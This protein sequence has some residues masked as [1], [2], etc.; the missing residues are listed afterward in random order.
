M[1][2]LQRILKMYGEI[3]VQGVIWV[4]DYKQDKARLKSE[5]TKEEWIESEKSKY[6]NLINKI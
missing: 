6:Q 5:M 4:W 2:G 3:N 1:A